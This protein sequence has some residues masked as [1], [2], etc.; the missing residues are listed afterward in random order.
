MFNSRHLVRAFVFALLLAAF[1]T[2]AVSRAHGQDFTLNALSGLHPVNPGGSSTANLDLEPKGGVAGPVSLTCTVT[3]T[4]LPPDAPACNVS[5]ASA[6]PPAQPALTVTTS[7]T[8]PAGT[9]QV[10]VTGTDGSG[11]ASVNLNM[12]VTPLTADYT[13]SVSPT[14]ASPSPV[15]AGNV[16]STTVTVT[17]IG[18]YT[19]QV[20]L[21]CLSVTPI[22]EAAPVCSFQP[23]LGTGPV[24]IT[25]GVPAS[26]TVT[27]STLGPFP[28]TKLRT[29][30]TFY[31]LWLAF[32]WL[33]LFGAA[34][35]RTRGKKLMGLLFLTAV[36]G[37]LLLL[38]ACG[39]SNHT[40][41]PQGLSTPKNTYTFTLT[42]VDQNG[43][44]PSNTTTNE[45]TVTLTVD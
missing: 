42:A 13:L 39:S 27:I 35:N 18:S 23:T 44:S 21:S 12:G 43:A 34:T 14:T 16:A 41:N 37:S 45:A 26:A 29:P 30:R 19:G 4:V 7:Q 25:N 22:V 2:V 6:T 40:N 8:T 9:Y 33:A 15:T 3:T 32:P 36:A 5:P 31:A 1:S 28:K 20:T 24:V 11:T 10:M 17:P 38:P